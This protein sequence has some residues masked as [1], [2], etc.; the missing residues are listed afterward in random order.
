[1][2]HCTHTRMLLGPCGMF[3]SSTVLQRSQPEGRSSCQLAR[4]ERGGS[5]DACFSEV[6]LQGLQRATSNNQLTI[7]GCD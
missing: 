4:C 7:A 3:A 1:M 6:A 2:P 5:C